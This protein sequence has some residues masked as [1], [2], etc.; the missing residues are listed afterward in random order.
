VAGI[1][2]AVAVAAAQ[3]VPVAAAAADPVAATGSAATTS[4]PNLIQQLT[5]LQS[6][7]AAFGS[8]V[9]AAPR[10]VSG[11]VYSAPTPP[12][13][14]Y[15][16]A[17]ASFRSYLAAFVG[18][19]GAL[20]QVTPMAQ[21]PN[22]E[23]ALSEYGAALAGLSPADLNQLYFYLSQ[24]PHW[25]EFPQILQSV[26]AEVA[27]YAPDMRGQFAAW[28]ATNRPEQAALLLGPSSSGGI[29]SGGTSGVT[30]TSPGS[31]VT[32]SDTS[33][34]SSAG[35]MVT[36]AGILSPDGAAQAP[37]GS[38]GA[39]DAFPPLPPDTCPP[40]LPYYAMIAIENGLQLLIGGLNK[41]AK[42]AE[43]DDTWGVIAL[44]EGVEITIPGIIH[45][46]LEVASFV[47]QGTLLGFT[48]VDE[49]HSACETESHHALLET[50]YEELSRTQGQIQANT[51]TLIAQVTA[52]TT[53]VNA[54]TATILQNIGYLRQQLGN[55]VST[56][57]NSQAAVISV[58]NQ[59]MLQ[60]L[61]AQEAASAARALQLQTE[62]QGVLAAS[63]ARNEAIFE[64]PASVGGY[65]NATPVG[66]QAVVSGLVVQM[67]Q[68]G[69]RIA[70]Q[71]L[72]ALALADR[73]LAVGQYKLAYALF[74]VAY[75]ILSYVGPVGG[76]FPPG[77]F[78]FPTGGTFPFLIGPGS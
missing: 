59:Q 57:L 9:Q 70:P 56:I 44:G 27:T 49:L 41:G 34:G 67:Q 38:S 46:V 53:I 29:A 25:Q 33:A 8:E 68:A 23:A 58:V 47:A 1:F 36:G 71:A 5:Q 76:P 69:E 6:Q 64:L 16:P 17:P 18:A 40:A 10:T 22:T 3:V 50:L 43:R 66:V 52:L 48:I 62:V 30:V 11:T 28:V 45:D 75:Q 4:V 51:V 2:L 32:A 42:L 12:Q 35:G 65:L 72:L 61:K 31:T 60:N 20:Q 73:A 19:L 55:E 63:F 39:A 37:A 7:I 26:R 13:P 14:S 24:A 21:G 15:P 74:K 78:G 54:R 77:H